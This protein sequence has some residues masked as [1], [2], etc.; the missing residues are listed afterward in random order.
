MKGSWASLLGPGEMLAWQGEPDGRLFVLRKHDIFMI[1]F[2]LLWGGFAIFWEY[3]A[4]TS[5]APFFFLLFGIPFVLIGLFMIIGRFFVDAHIRR[6]TDYA[7][8]NERVIISTTAFG[9]KVMAKPITAQTS[10]TL[11]PGPGGAI[12]FGMPETQTQPQFNRPQWGGRLTGFTFEL[13]DDADD[14]YQLVRRMQA[15]ME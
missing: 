4:Y 7:L 2:S 11:T 5:G 9:R 10:L 1:P 8:T 3:T 12:S 6:N 13:I 14:V 15:R